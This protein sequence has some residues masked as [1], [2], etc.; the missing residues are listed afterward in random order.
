VNKPASHP[1][2]NELVGRKPTSVTFVWDYIQFQFDGPCLTAITLPVFRTATSVLLPGS[3]GWRD[4]LCS[5]IG[6][7]VASSRIAD[8]ELRIEFVN[9]SGITVSL[10]DEDYTGPEAINY[11]ALDGSTMVV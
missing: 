10:A 5:A 3:A 6:V 9:S 8:D 2:T 7:E 4:G 11:E 1:K